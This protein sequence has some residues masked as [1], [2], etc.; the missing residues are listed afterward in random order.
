MYTFIKPLVCITVGSAL[1]LSVIETRESTPPR[2]I[3]DVDA[4]CPD[5]CQGDFPDSRDRK[6]AQA[7]DMLQ[8]A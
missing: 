2:D 7:P 4:Q 8:R 6:Y 1:F 5:K 3:P